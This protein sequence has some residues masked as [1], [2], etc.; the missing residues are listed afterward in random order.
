[1]KKVN[2]II[3]IYNAYEYTESCIKS[4]IKYTNLVLMKKS[5]QC[6]IS[7]KMNIKI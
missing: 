5:C 3:P 4:V 7:I 2:I 1:M 6:L